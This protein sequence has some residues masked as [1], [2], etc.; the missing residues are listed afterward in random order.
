[1]NLSYWEYKSWLANIDYTIVGSGIVGLTCALHLKQ[2][3][4]KANILILEKGALPQG[5]S[6][7]NAGFACFGSMSELLS[8]LKSHSEEEVVE[9]VKIRAEGLRQLRC[10]LGDKA[11]NF[12][13]F[14]GHELFPQQG[15]LYEHC[16]TKIEYLNSL[17]QPIF[18]DKVFSFVPNRFGFGNVKEQL[19]FNAFEGQ[20]HTGNMMKALLHEVHACGISILNQIHVINYIQC[21]DSVKIETNAFTFSSTH[22]L[23]ATNGFASELGVSEVMPARNQV[24]ITKPIQNLKI[25]GTFHLEQGYYYFRNIDN[26]ILLG[27]GRHLDSKGETTTELRSTPLIQKAL[28]DLLKKTILP[29]VDVD[30]EYSWSGILGLHSQ[31]KPILKQIDSTVFC[32]VGLGGMGVALGSLVGQRLAQLV[33]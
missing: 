3:F 10:L 26:R 18:K 7:K 21:C 16:L 1:M 19:G 5:A 14:G 28:E 17:L 24:L 29:E 13:P 30:I 6:T 12:Q 15:D 25:K 4:P 23:I 31:K 11:I 20:I 2:R 27:G 8:D 9:L 33:D 32:G 22:L